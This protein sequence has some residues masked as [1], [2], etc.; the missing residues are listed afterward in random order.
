MNMSNQFDFGKNWKNYSEYALSDVKIENARQHFNCLFENIDLKN[1]TFLDIGFGQGLSL[2]IATERSAK[3][4]GCD[5]NPLCK[6]VLEHNKT[7]F[8]TPPEEI[9]VIVGS[10]LDN[11]IVDKLLKLN[12]GL[13]F[14]IVHSW[15]VLHH[16]GNMWKAID[17]AKELVNKD[18]ILV[19]AIYN[20]HFSSKLWLKIKKLY[21]NSSR[22]IKAILLTFYLP[23]IFLRY[24]L[25]FQ[26]PL[27]LPRGMSLYYDAIDWLG[28]YPYEYASVGEISDYMSKDG[29]TKVKIVRTKG[30]TGCNEFIFRKTG[31]N[32][33]K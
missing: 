17:T 9:P 26:N 15:G 12:N 31:L 23:L 24:L 5:I 29:F 16:T 18:G 7:K 14:D 22:M 19:L 33:Q 11:S 30:F 8:N 10:I 32:S 13:L 2:L 21:N 25:I 20:K 6:E 28:G 1:K 27:K 4:M 3:T